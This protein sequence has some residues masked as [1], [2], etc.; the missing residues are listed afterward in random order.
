MRKHM[1]LDILG[2]VLV[3]VLFGIWAEGLG[4]MQS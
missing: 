1:I 4:P 2:A 3:L